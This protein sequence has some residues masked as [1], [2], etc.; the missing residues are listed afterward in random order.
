MRRRRIVGS[1]Y[2]RETNRLPLLY[3]VASASVR[4]ELPLDVV[5]GPRKLPE[6]AGVE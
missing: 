1:V 2:R 6:K 5:G 4:T 3:Y